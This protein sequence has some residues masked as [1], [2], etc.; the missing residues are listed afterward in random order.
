MTLIFYR[1]LVACYDN[2]RT[3]A[4]CGG[5]RQQPLPTSID[6]LTET[7]KKCGPM[8]KCWGQRIQCA[9]KGRTLHTE[10]GKA[11][12]EIEGKSQNGSWQKLS[13]ANPPAA[14]GR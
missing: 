12:E 3:R 9:E 4:Q 2:E 8:Y 6:T 7:G 5:L 10:R 13:E 1:C 14:D 11:R